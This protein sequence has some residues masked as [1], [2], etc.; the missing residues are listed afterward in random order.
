[1]VDGSNP[2]NAAWTTDVGQPLEAK[3]GVGSGWIRHYSG[4][5]AVVNPSPTATQS[6]P[7]GGSYV[8]AAGATVTSITHAPSSGAVLAALPPVTPR[9]T[10]TTTTTTTTTVPTTTTTTTTA[11]TTT[12][13][14]TTVTP[15][16][17][18][19]QA[20]FVQSKSTDSGVTNAPTV[21]LSGV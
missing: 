16:V 20:S 3:Q 21:S 12:T 10:P 14:T 1:G 6:F 19:P 4:G 15:S 13:T 18:T 5:V 11:P 7:L 17:A 2:V 8:T 9:T